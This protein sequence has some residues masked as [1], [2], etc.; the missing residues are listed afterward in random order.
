[1]KTTKKLLALFFISLS[2]ACNESSDKYEKIQCDV[3]SSDYQNGSSAGE[4]MAITDDGKRD[5]SY[6]YDNWTVKLSKAMGT[7][8]EKT[9]CYCK[10][11]Y[12]SY[13]KNIKNKK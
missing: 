7:L 3:S 1:M 8:P 5:C 12:D 9:D 4:I 13:D 11:F 10:G 6:G 2:F